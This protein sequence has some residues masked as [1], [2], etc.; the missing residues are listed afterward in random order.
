M[1]FVESLQASL[2]CGDFV[3]AQRADRKDV[4]KILSM[5][6]PEQVKVQWWLTREDSFFT[7]QMASLPPL[8]DESDYPNVKMC[9]ITECFDISSA[10]SILL[11]ADIQ[12]IAWVFHIDTLEHYWVNCAGMSRVFYVQY[13]Y[14]QDLNWSK[15]LRNDHSPFSTASSQS[16]PS[17]I[18]FSVLNII[19]R[20][21]LLMSDKR[22]L[23]FLRRTD[24]TFFPMESWCYISRALFAPGNH[25]CF[26]QKIAKK[27]MFADLSLCKVSVLSKTIAIRIAT[28][29]DMRIA[30]ELFGMTFCVASRNEYPSVRD[31][32]RKLLQNNVVNIVR[33]DGNTPT[34]RRNFQACVTE[35]GADL[36]FEADR[37]RLRLRVRYDYVSADNEDLCNLLNFSPHIME[38]EELNE[39][40]EVS[41]NTMFMMQDMLVKVI[42]IIDRRYV[43]VECSRNHNQIT[44]DYNEAIRLI[45]ESNKY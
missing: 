11:I 17:R 29:E 43:V 34:Y 8:L 32:P 30:R 1:V 44:L 7:E 35:H 31:P 28:P 33:V 18:W 22:Q 3:M 42:N 36:V 45:I 23:Q 19:K 4:C 21:H 27:Q 12:D 5:E 26:D 38:A 9:G 13:R 25:F 40:H 16:Y 41:L 24:T 37:Q 6:S 15:V 2:Y 10:V 20:F 39:L 14:D